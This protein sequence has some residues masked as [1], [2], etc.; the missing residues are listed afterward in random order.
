MATCRHCH[1]SEHTADCTKNSCGCVHFEPV[2][3][4]AREARK[5]LGLVRAAFY[6]RRGWTREIEVRVRAQTMTGAAMHGVQQ[7]RRQ[8]LAPRTRVQ[9]AR[10]T[11]TAC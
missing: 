11:V 10:M 4:A 9:Q 5:R 3:T 8:A 2:D 1:H 7:A 6:T